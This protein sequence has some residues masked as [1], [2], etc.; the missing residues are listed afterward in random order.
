MGKTVFLERPQEAESRW[1]I[2]DGLS[3]YITSEIYE[4]ILSDISF[5][6]CGERGGLFHNISIGTNITVISTAPVLLPVG[7]LY[8]NSK[9]SS[10]QFKTM[11]DVKFI[12]QQYVYEGGPKYFRNLNLPHKRDIV[13]G[14]ATRYGEPKIF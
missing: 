6:M 11:H 7:E 9:M 8:V 3:L 4:G 14:S 13:Q 1:K 10:T 5:V 2:C 12:F